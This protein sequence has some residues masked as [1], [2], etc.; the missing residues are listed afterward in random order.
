MIPKVIHYCWFGGNPLPKSA[1]KCINSW[2]K[3]FPDYEIKEWNESNYDVKKNTYLA[4]S[5][6]AKKYAFVSDYVRF[7]V[8]YHF[9]G[10]YF[11]TDVEVIKSFDDI[12][13][14]GSFMGCELDEDDSFAVNPGLGMAA[15]KGLPIYK[16][17][18]DFYE[19]LGEQDKK[20]IISS[21][22][23]VP[24]T[25]KI[26]IEHGMKNE[27]GIQKVDEITIYPSEYFN[28]FN[29]A[30]GELNITKQTHSIHW[31]TASWF[32]PTKRLRSKIIRPIHRWLGVGFFH[33]K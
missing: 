13:S 10:L 21:G 28:P 30:T 26:L 27:K 31:Y 4:L 25:T 18:L 16:K 11:D 8:L 15:E 7:D 23:V 32:S 33:R 24:Q 3:Y 2:K 1:V 20:K 14:S 19:S 29:S 22:F 12:L 5:Y 6:E 9:G 17:V